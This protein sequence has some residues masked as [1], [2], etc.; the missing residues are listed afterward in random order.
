MS[1]F[2]DD[3]RGNYRL[4]FRPLPPEF[5]DDDDVVNATLLNR[6]LEEE[7]R[8]DPAQYLWLHRRFKT[9]PE[10]APSLYD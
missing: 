6:M 7:I 1:Q 8:R 5:P 4:R 10:G 9:R 2:R 3:D